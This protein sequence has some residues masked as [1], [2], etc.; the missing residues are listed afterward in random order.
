[1]GP[2][3]AVVLACQPTQN[4]SY[5][6]GVPTTRQRCTALPSIVMPDYVPPDAGVATT[7]CG[8]DRNVTLAPQLGQVGA[9][10]RGT[11]NAIDGRSPSRA[12]LI[13]VLAPRPCRASTP[14]RLVRARIMPALGRYATANG[15]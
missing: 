14:T 5:G 9:Y 11:V 10:T 4:S 3:D 15:R 7:L 1:M 13:D 2:A 6:F 12:G 8:P